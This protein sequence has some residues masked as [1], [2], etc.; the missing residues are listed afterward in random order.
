[1]ATRSS[2]AER[3][4]VAST[5]AFLVRYPTETLPPVDQ[6]SLSDADVDA[7]WSRN[8]D[9]WAATYDERGDHTRKYYSDP[10]LFEFLGD[11]AG[12]TILDAGSGSGYLS[13]LLAQRGARMIA[14]ENALRFH[15][16]AVDY[17]R[18]EPLPIELH[19]GSISAMPFIASESVDAAVANFVLM[20]VLDYEAA[21]A[22]IARVLK[23]A[24]RFI[25]CS[26]T[27]APMAIG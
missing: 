13:R 7:N 2:G 19:H 14:V 12:K 22:E 6:R 26:P 9:L 11:V 8:A 16:I 1:M 23:P 20:D 25:S 15:E 4:P 21:I 27:Q 24:G 3:T 18:R 5:E 10:I 17:Q